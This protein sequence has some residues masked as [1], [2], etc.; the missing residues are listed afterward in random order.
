MLIVLCHQRK[1]LDSATSF[2]VG[3]EEEEELHQIFIED[4]L[5]YLI[6]K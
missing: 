4:L 1:Y 3:L 6:D 5:I 2:G